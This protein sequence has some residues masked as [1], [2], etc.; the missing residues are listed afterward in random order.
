[1][2][3]RARS[4]IREW[5]QIKGHVW[6]LDQRRVTAADALAAA[7]REQRLRYAEDCLDAL[8]AEQRDVIET[9]IQRLQLGV[10]VTGSCSGW[11]GRSGRWESRTP[12]SSGSA[13]WSLGRLAH[14]LEEMMSS[15]AAMW[16]TTRSGL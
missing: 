8:T 7:E 12:H 2:M 5:E 1:M 6:E 3:D 9:T 11:S 4:I 13:S 15:S 16:T 14:C 10:T